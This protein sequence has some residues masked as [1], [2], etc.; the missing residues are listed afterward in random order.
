MRVALYQCM[1]LPLNV[2]GKNLQPFG[3]GSPASPMKGQ[4]ADFVCSSDIAGA[5][6]AISS[7]IDICLKY[8]YFRTGKVELVDDSAVT[9]LGNAN[10][11]VINPLN[12]TLVDQ[13][14]NANLFASF[15][16][17]FKSHSLLASLIFNF[18]APPA[19]PPPPPPPPMMAAPPPPETQTCADGSVILATDSCPLPPPPPPSPPPAPERG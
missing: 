15:D 10:R 6:Y 17:K 12:P 11:F 7:N 16:Q 4:L 19:P 2:A 9:L 1:P 18:G 14:T 3:C 8:R 13:T 5:R